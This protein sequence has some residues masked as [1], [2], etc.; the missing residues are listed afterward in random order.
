M[1]RCQRRSIFFV[2]VRCPGK[3]FRP[4]PTAQPLR[5][6]RRACLPASAS[7][8]SVISTVAPISLQ[9]CKPFLNSPRD[10]GKVVVHG[11]TV[12]AGP[13]VR[14]NRIGIDTGACWTGCI[15]C[16]VLEGLPQHHPRL[17]DAISPRRLPG[18]APFAF[19]PPVAGF[20]PMRESRE[21]VRRSTGRG[22]C[23]E[24]PFAL[25]ARSF[26][27]S[28]RCSIR[29]LPGACRHVPR[30]SEAH[31]APRKSGIGVYWCLDRFEITISAAS[32]LSVTC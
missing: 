16:V 1:P 17:I 31:V 32:R 30:D 5:A 27:G 6:S 13:A 24:R 12:E 18:A 29:W 8:P 28:A 11:H 2:E 23:T 25:R 20:P 7:T 4:I 21:G 26:S 10:F 22:L 3:Q 19:R 9:R 14:P 15:T